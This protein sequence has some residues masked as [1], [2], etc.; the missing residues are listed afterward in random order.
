MGGQIGILSDIR[1]FYL[2]K[3][4]QV[5]VA[6]VLGCQVVVAARVLGCQGVCW[7]VCLF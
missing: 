4:V 3:V 5:V 1:E 2:L 6:R 7:V